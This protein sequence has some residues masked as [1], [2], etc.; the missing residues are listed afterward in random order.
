MQSGFNPSPHGMPPPQ[1]P[2]GLGY[3]MHN[4]GAIGAELRHLVAW[5]ERLSEL[6]ET[7]RASAET[8]RDEMRGRLARVEAQLA[9]QPA[10]PPPAPPTWAERLKALREVLTA[11]GW[12]LGLALAAAKA[13]HWLSPETADKLLQLVQR[14]PAP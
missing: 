7:G 2:H 11:L 5:V 4:L 12:P 3:L 8:F 1:D 13:F 9:A 14:G 10:S 6:H